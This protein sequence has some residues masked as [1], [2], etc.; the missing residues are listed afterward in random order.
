MHA[1]KPVRFGRTQSLI[2]ILCSPTTA[3]RGPTIVFVNAGIIHR[4][5]PNRLYVNLA[6]TLAASGFRS[7]RFDLGGIGDSATSR[8]ERGSVLDLVERDLRDAVDLASRESPDGRVV[9]IGLCSGADNAFRTAANDGRV[10]GAVLLDPNVHRTAGFY[11]R[12]YM[13][14]LFTPLTWKLL[15]TGEHPIRGRLARSVGLAPDRQT[16]DAVV[17][18]APTSLPPRNVMRDQIRSLLD[19][20][21]RLF[22]VFTAGL[23]YRYNHARQFPKTFPQLHRHPHLRFRY[24]P[25]RDHTFS[26]AAS[27]RA[28]TDS[29]REWLEKLPGAGAPAVRAS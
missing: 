19:R 28:L 14:A 8:E 17:F 21:C 15:L 9:L 20:G 23:P 22:Y 27:Q 1:E 26:D 10:A 25:V 3:S 29:I 13:R 18:L 5:G 6:R 4:V 2:G 7:L 24:F 16:S 11:V 12:K